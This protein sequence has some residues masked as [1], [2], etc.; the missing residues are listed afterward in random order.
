MGTWGFCLWELVWAGGACRDPVFPSEVGAVVNQ[1]GLQSVKISAT[2][3]H[4]GW[5]CACWQ[6]SANTA[7]NLSEKWAQKGLRPEQ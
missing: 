3:L 2:E 6:N 1:L 7:D 5:G 4:E